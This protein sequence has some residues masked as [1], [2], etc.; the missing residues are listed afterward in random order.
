MIL[1][2]GIRMARA[3]DRK[4]LQ[5]EVGLKIDDLEDD[6]NAELHGEIR[7]YFQLLID[8]IHR[9]NLI[10]FV[11]TE[12]YFLMKKDDNDTIARNRKIDEDIVVACQNLE[13]MTR[14]LKIEN[15]SPKHRLEPPLGQKP[16]SHTQQF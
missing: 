15:K 3:I 11:H 6:A 5:D 4:T 1:I 14:K 10:S 2:D 9:E 13:R 8:Y 16:A 12:G 7:E